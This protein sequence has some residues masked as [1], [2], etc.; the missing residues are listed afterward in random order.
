MW[1]N[2]KIYDDVFVDHT[3]L[4]RQHNRRL[5]KEAFNNPLEFWY[6]VTPLAEIDELEKRL[7]RDF[8]PSANQIRYEES[9]HG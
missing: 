6:A 2:R 7:I 3:H 5:G 8:Q 9:S 4:A 1:V